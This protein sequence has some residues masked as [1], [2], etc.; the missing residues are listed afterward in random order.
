MTSTQ[1]EDIA[2]LEQLVATLTH[3]LHIIERQIAEYGL[4]VPPHMVL[5]KEQT[6]RELAQASGALRR[7]RG[8]TLGE[9]APYLGL[10][11]FH[12]HDA[13]LFFGREAL[14]AELIERIRDAPFLAVLGPSGSGKPSFVR[15]GLIPALKQGVAP[16]SERWC[17]ITVKPGARPLDI[18][19]A[20]L[21]TA[22]GKDLT[23]ALVLSRALAENERA[24]LVAADLLL[25]AR[26]GTRLVLVV[27]QAE[28]LWTLTPT[29]QISA[30][31]LSSS[32]SDL[33]SGCCSQQWQRLP[34]RCL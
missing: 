1:L 27:D 17:Y 26:D 11:T 23:S 29:E 6:R 28:E 8:N 13:A 25:V 20:A 34:A 2:H 22:L 30:R 7:A 18:L 3:R 24:L 10:A 4:A 5:D 14:V 9:H 33:L 32:S 15:A 21:T 31:H 16:N 19:A 12:E